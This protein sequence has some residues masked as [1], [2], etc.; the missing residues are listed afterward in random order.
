MSNVKSSS[1]VPLQPKRRDGSYIDER[2]GVFRVPRKAFVDPEILEREREAIFSRCWL[3]VGHESELPKPN[4][5]VKRSVGGREIIFNRDR[6]GA[7]H[8][9]FNTC[10]HRGAMVVREA[11]GSA[12][13]FRCFYHGWSFNN[14]GKFATK[15]QPGMYPENFNA[16]G[17]ANL[18]AV[19]RL[20]EYRGFWFV[21]YDKDAI[22][23]SDYLADAKEYLSIV[24]DHGPTGM[25]IVGGVQEYSVRAN[26]KLLVENSID[27]YHAHETHSTYLEY[28]MDAIGGPVELFP[29][30]NNVSR[31]RDL[32]NGHAVIEG[33]GPWGRPVAQW[34]PAW[35]EKGKQDI[36]A[37]RAE[38]E[39]RLGPD[40]AERVALGNR[41]LIIFPNLIINDIMAITVRTFYPESADYMTV[42]SWALAPKGEAK[43]FRKRRLDNFLEFLGPGGFATPDDVEALEACQRGYRNMKEV[44]WNDISKGM[45]RDAP[46]ADDEE[47]MRCFWREWNRRVSAE[48]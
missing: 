26:W 2:P 8:A 12:I 20:E 24:A 6:T 29:S 44:G 36:A 5:F 37:I 25:E 40:Y 15:F 38:L 14:N 19:P 32:G 11:K 28:L 21:N 39:A 7:F 30:K 35:G 22:S 45:L 47:Q 16:D 31:A 3:Y 17:C 41:N 23:L 42:N 10:P 13:S 1:A 48:S 46:L 18:V 33:P 9:F 34:I 27:G 43:D 4:D